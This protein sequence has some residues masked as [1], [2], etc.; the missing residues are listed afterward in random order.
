MG[1]GGGGSSTSNAP[2]IDVYDNESFVNKPAAYAIV[3]VAYVYSPVPVEKY[4]DADY[5]V[6]SLTGVTGGSKTE[7][8]IYWTPTAD[9]VG[10]SHMLEVQVLS[11]TEN[12]NFK[13]SVEVKP[14]TSLPVSAGLIFDAGINL[15]VDEYVPGYKLNIGAT[16]QFPG[17]KLKLGMA[18]VD[19]TNDA[20]ADGIKS[21]VLILDFEQALNPEGKI[22]D[23]T[24]KSLSLDVAIKTYTTE[25]PFGPAEPL[26]D[27]KYFLAI[28]SMDSLGAPPAPGEDGINFIPLKYNEGELKA[29]LTH[30]FKDTAIPARHR[31]FMAQLVNS[32]YLKV[33]S[34]DGFFEFFWLFESNTDPV[35]KKQYVLDFIAK[36]EGYFSTSAEKLLALGCSR[37]GGVTKTQVFISPRINTFTHIYKNEDQFTVPYVTM[38]D[39]KKWSYGTRDCSFPYVDGKGEDGAGTRVWKHAISHEYFHVAQLPNSRIGHIYNKDPRTWLTESS[40]EFASEEIFPTQSFLGKEF[41]FKYEWTNELVLSGLTSVGSDYRSLFPDY[42]HKNYKLSMFFQYI[43]KKRNGDLNICSFIKSAEYQNFDELHYL[44]LTTSDEKLKYLKPLDRLLGGTGTE[45]LDALKKGYSNFVFAYNFQIQEL[46]PHI[47][48]ISNFNFSGYLDKIYLSKEALPFESI[49]SESVFGGQSI[50]LISDISRSVEIDIKA[51]FDATLIPSIGFYAELYPVVKNSSG[52]VLASEPVAVFDGASP[53]KTIALEANQDYALVFIQSNFIAQQDNKLLNF[54]YSIEESNVGIPYVYNYSLSEGYSLGSDEFGANQFKA[55]STEAA[56]YVIDEFNITYETTNFSWSIDFNYLVDLRFYIF[57]WDHSFKTNFEVRMAASEAFDDTPPEFYPS[58]D[59]TVNLENV[60]NKVIFNEAALQPEL[61]LFN[62]DMTKFNEPSIN[63]TR[64]VVAPNDLTRFVRRSQVLL[65]SQNSSTNQLY[66]VILFPIVKSRTVCNKAQ[67]G[68]TSEESIAFCNN[69]WS[70]RNLSLNSF[71]TSIN[72]AVAV[73]EATQDTSLWDIHYAYYVG[74][75]LINKV[76]RL[77][78][79]VNSVYDATG[80]IGPFI[81]IYA[82]ILKTN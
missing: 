27:E 17:V 66:N 50:T 55:F 40:A 33:D 60:E 36:S 2:I 77:N 44:Q 52:E 42:S 82:I 4:F 56:S 26:A 62:L 47:D 6:E 23:I 39:C 29:F 32:K 8:A 75:K 25:N 35:K 30:T 14:Q 9:D 69:S 68:M 53:K 18:D 51:E 61:S 65:P 78:T 79:G 22:V 70:R 57:L 1:C 31:F 81:E 54:S 24:G 64:E 15:N 28:Q 80:E 63:L 46:I 67:I 13:W 37:P 58:V 74:N 34:S 7:K 49:V 76:Y 43:K 38:S 45:R 41:S 16:D 5:S 48:K 10:E 20:F 11:G 71:E 72:E 19:L 12:L 21:P 73:A 3:G 59:D